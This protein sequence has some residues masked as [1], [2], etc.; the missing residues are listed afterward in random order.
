MKKNTVLDL[1][2]IKLLP[3]AGRSISE[4]IDFEEHGEFHRDANGD[5]FAILVPGEDKM[6]ITYT[7]SGDWA[8]PAIMH[9][10]LLSEL[11]VILIDR[12]HMP[13]EAGQTSVTLPRAAWSDGDMSVFLDDKTPVPR[14]SWT[15]ASPRVVTLFGQ[16]RSGFVEF[17]PKTRAFLI[18]KPKDRGEWSGKVNW[19]IGLVEK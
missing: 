19:T 16:A 9:V 2:T 14:P 8:A 7:C 17:R 10:P 12:W 5:G 3:G 4:S 18:Q 6:T 13:F 1:S 11:D 15:W